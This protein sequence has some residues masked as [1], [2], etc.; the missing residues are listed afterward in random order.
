MFGLSWSTPRVL[1]KFNLFLF[2]SEYIIYI[3]IS[4]EIKFMLEN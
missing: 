1:F 3:N 2:E 4:I